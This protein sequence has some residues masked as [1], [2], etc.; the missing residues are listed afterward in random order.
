MLRL[1]QWLG[2]IA[3]VVTHPQQVTVAALFNTA[4]GAVGTGAVVNAT[5]H[6]PARVDLNCHLRRQIVQELGRIGP[7]LAF[8]VAHRSVEADPLHHRQADP[9]L[10]PPAQGNAK[11]ALPEGLGVALGSLALIFRQA[12]GVFQIAIARGRVKHHVAI[13]FQRKRI[14]VEQTAAEP[15]ASEVLRPQGTGEHKG[16]TEGGIRHLPAPG[17]DGPGAWQPGTQGGQI[18][19]TCHRFGRTQGLHGGLADPGRPLTLEL[20]AINRSQL[21][22]QL[23]PLQPAGCTRIVGN[24]RRLHRRIGI[25]IHLAGEEINHAIG[26]F[27]LTFTLQ[28]V[29]TEKTGLQILTATGKT[30]RTAR[31]DHL[32][33]AVVFKAISLQTPTRQ[34]EAHVARGHKT[35]QRSIKCLL[36]RLEFQ[37][38]GRASRG[39]RPSYRSRGL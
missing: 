4:V 27:Q 32:G 33:G 37:R 17:G 38:K 14:G 3:E 7:R 39:S 24:R 9:G 10:D 13:E 34:Q 1:G 26:V 16:F 25:E 15:K 12:K 19:W 8:V 20:I 5:H 28:Q 11:G 6:R 36:I 30:H 31:P 29:V 23:P 21:L 18:R 2:G 22:Q 35:V